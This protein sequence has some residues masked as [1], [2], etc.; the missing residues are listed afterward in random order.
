MD[1]QL[2]KNLTESDLRGKRVLLR[3][4][5]NVPIKD[6]KMVDDFRIKKILPTIEF[7]KKN[8]AR[9]ICISHHSS[10]TQ[11]LM[12]VAEYLKEYFPV[13]FTK[14]V[15]AIENFTPNDDEVI[16]A[17]NIRFHKGEKK[18][19]PI[20]AKNLASLADLYVNDAFSVS[21]RA[22]ASIT[23]LP[24][25]LPS[26]IG[27][28]FEEEITHL[29]EL[30]N[31]P[32]PLLFI[33]GGGKAKQ[34][35]YLIEA[36]LDTVDTLFVCGILGNVFLNAGGYISYKSTLPADQSK[37]ASLLKSG[38]IVLPSDLVVQSENMR[39]EKMLKEITMGDNIF[40]VGEETIA[41]IKKS[42]AKAKCVLWNG[43]PGDYLIDG[44]EHGSKKLAHILAD[45]KA[46]TI[47]GGG[48][49]L[50][51][52]GGEGL[53]DKFDFV[54]TGGGAMLEFLSKKTL[55]GIDALKDCAK[56]KI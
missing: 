21:H 15:F 41:N 10:E 36:F 12:P 6:G 29:S 34:K 42:V 32:H 9:V 51:V 4:D 5:F 56:G 46:Q 17:E 55:L 50:A 7:L 35:F 31:P 25:F 44:F 53:M 13:H 11:S 14:D 30:F 49:T 33:L 23:S 22:H 19:D 20:F 48:D 1:I 39:L 24:A 54:S 43:P 40:D 37:V 52:I 16:V 38:K 2:L 3:T 28:L 45:A 18:N 8:N 47:A 27:F 26:Y